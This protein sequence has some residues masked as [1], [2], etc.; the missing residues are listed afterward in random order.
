MFDF[1]A[2]LR[3]HFCSPS[4]NDPAQ[5]T[6]A[7]IGVIACIGTVLVARRAY[8]QSFK[9]TEID[10]ELVRRFVESAPLWRLEALQSSGDKGAEPEPGPPSEN[11][12]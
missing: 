10:D 12:T 3:G 2:L 6:I 7:I 9:A 4:L 1:P 5:A 11:L 8:H